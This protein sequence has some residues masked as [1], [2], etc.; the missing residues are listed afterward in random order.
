ME[1]ANATAVSTSADAARPEMRAHPFSPASKLYRR[2]VSNRPR[3]RT[4]QCNSYLGLMLNLTG[5]QR[6]TIAAAPIG[7][8]NHEI[9]DDEGKTRENAR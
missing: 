2:V 1:A 4:N 7:A 9:Y 6:T 8:V 5:L 3:K